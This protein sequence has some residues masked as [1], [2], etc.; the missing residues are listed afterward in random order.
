MRA[1]FLVCVIEA[2]GLTAGVERV[3]RAVG[4]VAVA[5]GLPVVVHTNPHTHSGLVA[6]RVLAEEGVDLT[7][8]VL[9]HSGDSTD[10]DYLMRVADAGSVL[11]MDRFGLDLLL[12]H[13][14]RVETVAALAARGY[15][16]RMV[17]SQDAFCYSDWFDAAALEAV[18]D[19]W[20]YFQVTGRVL[21]DLRA[22]GVADEVITAMTQLTPRRLLCPDSVSKPAV[23]QRI[24]SKTGL[25]P[26]N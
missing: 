15:G 8:V 13:A 14:A 4:R 11:G 22:R 5:T 2:E 1:G 23:V 16:D 9:A 7:R 10:L 24:P 17:L 20:D 6:Q 12:P 25:S 3:M 18:G 19:D 21:P 26:E